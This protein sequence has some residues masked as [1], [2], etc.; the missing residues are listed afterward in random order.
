M[1]DEMVTLLKAEQSE[2]DSRK[3]YCIK[4]FD[5]TR[6][7]RQR[8]IHKH[9]IKSYKDQLS[10]TDD[11]VEALKNSTDQRDSS[12]SWTRRVSG[13]VTRG[14]KCYLRVGHHHTHRLARPRV[15]VGDNALP[16]PE[17]ALLS[18]CARCMRSPC[19]HDNVYHATHANTGHGTE[20]AL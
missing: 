20:L 13:I 1:I 10:N 2:D 15:C 3:E 4:C 9:A 7:R 14:P 12:V 19:Q 6:G 18:L 8:S 17:N 16:P 5:E 11:R